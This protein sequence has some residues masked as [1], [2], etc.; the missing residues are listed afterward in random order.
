M[1]KKGDP[2][3]IT[4]LFHWIY[5]GLHFYLFSYHHTVIAEHLCNG[6]IQW[7]GIYPEFHNFLWIK[8]VESREEVG[9]PIDWSSSCVYILSKN[10]K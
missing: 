9:A 4:F 5:S 2:V 10:M 1:N 3:K 6:S 7:Y 8:I